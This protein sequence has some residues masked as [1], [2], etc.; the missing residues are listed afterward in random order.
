MAT[1]VG[2]LCMLFEVALIFPRF[3]LGL[4]VSNSI[5]RRMSLLSTRARARLIRGD[6]STNY[7]IIG[8]LLGLWV[9]RF[10][11]P[12]RSQLIV[13]I[14]YSSRDTTTPQKHLNAFYHRLVELSSTGVVYC[15]YA[16]SKSTFFACWDPIHT[17]HKAATWVQ[18]CQGWWWT[19][20]RLRLDT[21]RHGCDHV[22]ARSGRHGLTKERK[23]TLD[24]ILTPCNSTCRSGSERCTLCP[25]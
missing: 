2:R 15:R 4:L 23:P 24:R 18:G 25:S 6:G 22:P 1:L 17:P 19:Y 10:E 16:I 21:S 9:L 14:W 5:Y 20:G 7:M 3:D 11:S 13:I 12:L 8:F